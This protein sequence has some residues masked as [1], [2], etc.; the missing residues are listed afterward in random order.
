MTGL[1]ARVPS[2]AACVEKQ[3]CKTWL[4]NAVVQNKAAECAE[5]ACRTRLQ[6][7]FVQNK[8]AE[9]GSAGISSTSY[10]AGSGTCS[11]VQDATI[12]QAVHS[13]ADSQAVTLHAC[14]MVHVMQQDNRA[15]G[16]DACLKAHAP[17]ANA[18]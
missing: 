9:C 3:A 6:N 1:L 5:Q 7:A 14:R 12:T 10:S 11:F 18:L 8:A 17:R 16:V 13:G 2:L 15:Q 4:Q